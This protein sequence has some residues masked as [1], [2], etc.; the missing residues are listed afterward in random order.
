[1]RDRNSRKLADAQSARRIARAEENDVSQALRDHVNA[2]LY[3]GAHEDVAE[4]AVALHE[5]LEASAVDDDDFA[6]VAHAR[7]QRGAA[8]GE[9]ADVA[10][11]IPRGVHDHGNLGRNVR[12]AEDF[13]RPREHDDEGHVRVA[14]LDEGFAGGD[15][16]PFSVGINALDLIGSERRKHFCALVGRNGIGGENFGG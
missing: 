7:V 6:G 5:L 11:E 10:E 1:L 4:F 13:E 15:V 9:H 16:A 2:A 12:I 8:L 3:E 14:L